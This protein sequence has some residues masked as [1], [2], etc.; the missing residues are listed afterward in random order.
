MNKDG[1]GNEWTTW[2]E[3][4]SDV[5]VPGLN[6]LLSTVISLGWWGM[7]VQGND[8]QPTA[9]WNATVVNV[10]ALIH[11]KTPVT[12]PGQKCGSAG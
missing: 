4:L 5:S 10:A 8:G 9:A 6:G 1:F 11:Q 2:W 12:L 3:V 7:L